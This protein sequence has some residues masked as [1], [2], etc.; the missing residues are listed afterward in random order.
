MKDTAVKA[1]RDA[2]RGYGGTV[3]ELKQGKTPA[4]VVSEHA[5]ELGE[6]IN[7][8][9]TNNSL[10]TAGQG[11]T[12]LELFQEVGELDYLFVVIGGGGILAGALQVAEKLSPKCKVIGVEQEK[13]NK[14]QLTLQKGE[15]VVLP[16]NGDETIADGIVIGYL[17]E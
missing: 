5:E 17:G 4:E 11:T 14:G 16:I 8:D 7:I 6:A 15:K 3:I 13:L 10:V 1:K 2:A 12:T 9:S